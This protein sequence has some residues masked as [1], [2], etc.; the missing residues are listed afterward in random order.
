VCSVNIMVFHTKGLASKIYFGI[1]TLVLGPTQPPIQWVLGVKW[2]GGEADHSPTNSA[3]VQNTWIYTSTPPYTFIVW[4]LMSEAQG[5]IY[6][7][8]K[9][10]YGTQANIIFFTLVRNML[11]F[12]VN[13]TDTFLQLFSC[14]CPELLSAGFQEVYF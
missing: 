2:L 10:C 9:S 3:E 7:T 14:G 13:G 6:L 4:Y 1:V 5:Q 12:V 8:P 11:I